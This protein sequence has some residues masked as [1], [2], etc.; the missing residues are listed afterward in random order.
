MRQPK[1]TKENGYRL[2]GGDFMQRKL[3]NI[4]STE[5]QMN[6]RISMTFFRYL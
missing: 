5:N 1:E 3:P 2:R 4:F 6:F